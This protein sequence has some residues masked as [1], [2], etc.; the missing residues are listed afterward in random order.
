MRLLIA[1]LARFG[2]VGLIGFVIDVGVF[3][4]LRATILEPSVIH[5]G[6]FIAKVISTCLAIAANYVGNR[7]W[8]FGA[9][10]REQVVREGVEF[11]IVSVGGTLLTL[12]CLWISHYALGFTSVLA[13]NISGNVVGLAL[14]TVFRFAFYRSWVFHPSRSMPL[15]PAEGA[16]L[17]AS[18]APGDG[19]EAVP[20]VDNRA[21]AHD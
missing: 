20:A 21:G 6:P 4:L 9:T 8:T 13:D 17:P 16:V 5:E 7:Y 18:A 11:V 19:V 1:Q 3:N 2:V 14:G 12:A 10:K 15:R